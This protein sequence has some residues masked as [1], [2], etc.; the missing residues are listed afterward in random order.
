MDA[1]ETSERLARSLKG[2]W[3]K[4]NALCFLATANAKEAMASVDTSV[5]KWSLQL[6]ETHLPL[7]KIHAALLRRD[8]FDRAMAAT[9]L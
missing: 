7:D 3:I 8:R 1:A 5:S 2:L 9:W 6:E 4:I